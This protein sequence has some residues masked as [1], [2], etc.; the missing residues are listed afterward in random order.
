MSMRLRYVTNTYSGGT[1]GQSLERHY[2]ELREEML[3]QGRHF[4]LLQPAAGWR[5]PADIH[6]TPAALVVKLELAGVHEDQL[7][8]TLYQDALVI[9]GHRDD[10]SEHEDDV[11]YHEAQV[12]YGPFRAEI[13]L[14]VPVVPE[15]VHATYENGFLRVR[16]PK[17]L[18]SAPGKGRRDD[19]ALH[20]AS[21]ESLGPLN[22][23]PP[24]MPATGAARVAIT[25]VRSTQPP[26]R[27]EV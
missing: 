6:E 9:A 12:H 8:I 14:P 2:R 20:S 11:C 23:T 25:A 13:L 7:E 17:A 24:G 18:A 15:A 27:R 5:P 10:D 19:L 1:A 3:H 16:L 22:A 21:G 4:G 26:T